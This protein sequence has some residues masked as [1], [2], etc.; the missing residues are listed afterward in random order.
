[1]LNYTGKLQ[2]CPFRESLAL[3]P[4]AKQLVLLLG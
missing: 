1:M 4:P 3:M 2:A